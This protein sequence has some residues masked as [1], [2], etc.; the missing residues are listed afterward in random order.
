[1]A[2]SITSLIQYFFQSLLNPVAARVSVFIKNCQC[3]LCIQETILNKIP[4]KRSEIFYLNKPLNVR[5]TCSCKDHEKGSYSAK[6]KRGL[7][8]YSLLYHTI[9]NTANQNA[10][11]PLYIRQYSTEP[12][13]RSVQFNC[14]T[15]NLPIWP[16]YFLW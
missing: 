6:Y 8:G 1:M 12:F 9:E 10:E 11:K 3:T 4:Q 5:I 16:L 15:P 7:K 13:H 14:I 2:C